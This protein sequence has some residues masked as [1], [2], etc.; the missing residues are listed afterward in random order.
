MTKV[1]LVR[2]G[3]RTSTQMLKLK[4]PSRRVEVTVE[5]NTRGYPG[6]M[7][8]RATVFDLGTWRTVPSLIALFFSP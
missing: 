5:L 2:M 6:G 1:D 3:D 4:R 8:P 7:P